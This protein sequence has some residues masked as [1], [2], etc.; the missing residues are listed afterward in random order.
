MGKLP[1]S[2]ETYPACTT[3]S[4][5]PINT[6]KHIRLSFSPS[7]YCA[8]LA[9]SARFPRI[10]FTASSCGSPLS[11]VRRRRIRAERRLT[12]NSHR[13]NLHLHRSSHSHTEQAKPTMG[14]H[15]SHGRLR[16]GKQG[17]FVPSW[18]GPNQHSHSARPLTSPSFLSVAWTMTDY[19]GTTQ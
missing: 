1:L 12:A 19:D 7:S 10:G 15:N 8:C 17:F 16:L 4:S 5:L 14:V 2:R 6:G 18:V 3:C 9:Q 11:T 13:I